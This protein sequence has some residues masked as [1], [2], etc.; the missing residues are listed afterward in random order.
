[1]RISLVRHGQPKFNAARSVG[2]GDIAESLF[3]YGDS[4]VSEVWVEAA[5]RYLPLSHGTVVVTSE[6]RRAYRSA[7]ILGLPIFEC[8]S[9]LNESRLP[10]PKT[11]PLRLPWKLAIVVL[12]V[13]WLFGYSR[14]ADG[15]NSDKQRAGQAATWLNS[16]AEEHDEVI[17]IGHGMM[18]RLIE[19]K[20]KASGWHRS[21]SSGRGYWSCI[22]L[23]RDAA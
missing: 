21:H 14:C 5:Q 7:E 1:M 23:E 20:L 16:L 15:I 13:A 22:E 18:H 3:E 17:A 6:L 8:S 12:R 4:D 10:Y 9:L 2:S 19:M 11:F